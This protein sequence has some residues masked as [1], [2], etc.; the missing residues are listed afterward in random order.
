MIIPFSEV[1]VHYD[2]V[3]T[4]RDGSRVVYLGFTRVQVH[5]ETSDEVVREAVIKEM[6]PSHDNF[7]ITEIH[8]WGSPY[9][10]EV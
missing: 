1:T 5:K 2:Y 4:K 8:R 7:R 9:L 6:G 10:V 3:E